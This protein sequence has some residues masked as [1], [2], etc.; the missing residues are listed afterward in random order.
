LPRA[1]F[2]RKCRLPPGVHPPLSGTRPTWRHPHG[3]RRPFATLAP[4]GLSQL[5][6]WWIKLGIVHQRITP[7]HPEQNGRHE[8]M[9]RT[10]KREAVRH[11]E[12][13]LATQQVRFDRFQTEYNAERPHEAL[14]Y[15]TPASLYTAS[16]RPYPNTLPEPNYPGH[17]QKRWVS[18]AGTF[19]FRQGRQ[20]FLSNALIHEWIGLEEVEEGIWSIY[21]YDVLIARFDERREVIVR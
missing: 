12:A 4:G 18:K 5:S 20:L 9:H 19:R 14:E 7:A 21:F 3:Q 11:P 13:D 8:R 1:P 10:L 16:S 15:A 6:I 2:G 17:F